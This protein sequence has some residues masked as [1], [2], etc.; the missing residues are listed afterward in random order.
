[1]WKSMLAK[2]FSKNTGINITVKTNIRHTSDE[3]IIIHT[4]TL[5]L[6]ILQFS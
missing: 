2:K 6:Q 5:T 3:E 1:M 4:M